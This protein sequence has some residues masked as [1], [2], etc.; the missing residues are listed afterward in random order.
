MMGKSKPSMQRV[1][2]F[3]VS[4]GRLYRDSRVFIGV[5]EG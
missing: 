4:L 5:I 1:V 3:R 2:G